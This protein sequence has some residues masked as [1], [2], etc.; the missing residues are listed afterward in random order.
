MF[1]VFGLLLLK[2]DFMYFVYFMCVE[3]IVR[4]A[5]LLWSQQDFE[6]R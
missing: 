6:W 5:G 2:I 3:V 4:R 1:L